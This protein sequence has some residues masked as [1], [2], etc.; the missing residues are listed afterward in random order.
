MSLSCAL[1]GSVAEEEDTLA[2]I[3]AQIHRDPQQQPLP[4]PPPQATTLVAMRLVLAAVF[5][6]HALL[7]CSAQALAAATSASGAN[8]DALVDALRKGAGH[9][10]RLVKETELSLARERGMNKRLS[11]LL[12]SKDEALSLLRQHCEPLAKQL[13]AKTAELEQA[14][15]A[16]AVQGPRIDEIVEAR[17]DEQRQRC[18]VAAQAAKQQ[19]AARLNDSQV[20]AQTDIAKLKDALDAGGET[21]DARNAEVDALRKDVRTLQARLDDPKLGEWAAKKWLKSQQALRSV[22]AAKNKARSVLAPVQTAL[23]YITLVKRASSH[24]LA[25]V[26]E[27]DKDQVDGALTYVFVFLGVVLGLALMRRMRFHLERLVLLASLQQTAVFAGLFVLQ[28][29]TST[30]VLSALLHWSHAAHDGLLI[31]C[32]ALAIMYW[33]LLCLVT[34]R[35]WLIRDWGS[36]RARHVVQLLSATYVF[37]DFHEMYFAPSMLN[38][39]VSFEAARWGYYALATLLVSAC[40]AFAAWQSKEAPEAPMA[41]K[42]KRP[43]AARNDVEAMLVA[44]VEEAGGEAVA[45]KHD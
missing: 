2:S 10:E 31:V 26:L 41:K 23:E 29:Y 25:A 5:L 6:L 9:L 28:E 15:Q 21:L 35:Q 37:V 45:P 30:D 44:V 36:L 16:A 42:P 39:G 38:V 7:A 32:G 43:K 3:H 22:E 13:D 27:S 40:L 12:E 33:L 11:E 14:L 1:L 17:V 24:R 34:L 19:C 8:C 4:P 20:L 18:A